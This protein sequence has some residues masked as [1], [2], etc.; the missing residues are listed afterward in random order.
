MTS[1]YQRLQEVT[2]PGQEIVP[3]LVKPQPVI[4]KFVFFIPCL[5]VLFCNCCN[6]SLLLLLLRFP[7]VFARLALI[8][9][10]F[11]SRYPALTCIFVCELLGFS[12]SSGVHPCVLSSCSGILCFSGPC[13]LS[14]LCVIKLFLDCTTSL[15]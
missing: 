7:Q 9:F 12:A 11:L 14:K 5:C 10:Q 15:S 1:N 2:V 13:K 6:C 4:L 8:T 3:L